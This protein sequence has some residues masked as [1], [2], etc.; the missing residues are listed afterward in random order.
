MILGVTVYP[1]S[2]DAPVI[3][4]I[5]GEEAGQYRLGTCT[6]RW[7]FI[8]A[9]IATVEVFLLTVFAFFLAARQAKYLLM[10][11]SKDR[12]NNGI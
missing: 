10:Y 11:A 7:P 3:R 9:C 12:K 8:L 5:C 2:W 1:M 6:I 4:L